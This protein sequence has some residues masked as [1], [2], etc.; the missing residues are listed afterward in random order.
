MVG[1]SESVGSAQRK[2]DKKHTK[3]QLKTSDSIYHKIADKGSQAGKAEKHEKVF[4]EF[5]M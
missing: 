3:V 5:E 2:H 4:A 1:G